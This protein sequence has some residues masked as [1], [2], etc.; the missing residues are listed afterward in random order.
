MQTW[1][2]RYEFSGPGFVEVE[3]KDGQVRIVGWEQSAVLV[4]AAWPGEGRIE[5]RLEVGVAENRI[6]LHVKPYRTGLFGLF[7]Y[8]TLLDLEIFVPMTSRC[9]VES[10][11]G[12]VTVESTMGQ[13]DVEAGSGR[14]LAAGVA[15][16]SVETG[17]G[18][19]QA[20]Q[21]NG[22]ANI[23]TG[24]GRIDLDAAAGPVVL[25][26]GSGSV[27]ARRIGNGL[28]AHTA[29]GSI[30]VADVEGRVDLESGSGSI[31]VSRV[32]APAV[33][34]ETGSGS[35]RLQALDV[36]K[37][38]VETGSGSV[39]VEL[40]RIHPDGS[41]KLETGSGRVTVSIPKDAGLLLELETHGR[42]HYGGLPVR[43]LRQ[44]DEEISAVVG[45]GGPLLAIETGSGSINLLAGQS[46]A[47]H[48][49][50]EAAVARVAGLVKD[51][52]ALEQSEQMARILQ[53][54]GEGKLSV[55]EAEKLLRAL[56][57]EEG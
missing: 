40:V 8:D 49:E 39:E 3:Q 12:P 44:D 11:S 19:V 57:D 16:L 52:P 33:A 1:E 21:I 32:A 25:E 13:T 22:P 36:H 24:S 37:L 14:V 9:A 7:N 42:V 31:A 55:E 56:D 6:R 47:V 48:A 35:V 28:K 5:D 18:S 23:Q 29:S 34:V 4:K 30:A 20:R 53:M 46:A 54:V 38:E 10:G 51:D 17:S 27:T 43:V 50:P 45:E 15:R 26:A 41:Y 2:Q